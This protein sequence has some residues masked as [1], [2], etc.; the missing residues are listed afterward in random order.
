MWNAD[1][2]ELCKSLVSENT[3]GQGAGR[4]I[5]EWLQK[6]ATEPVL[7]FKAHLHHHLVETNKF[8]GSYNSLN[9]NITMW[10]KKKNLS[11]TIRCNSTKIQSKSQ[12]GV[13]CERISDQVAMIN[14]TQVKKSKKQRKTD[15]IANKKI[16]L[17]VKLKGIIVKRLSVKK[18]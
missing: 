2:Y 6:K 17:L 15:R 10:I 7:L 4:R 12:N 13:I 9:S 3:D 5:V 14:T 1:F 18:K 16:D 11:D 8:A